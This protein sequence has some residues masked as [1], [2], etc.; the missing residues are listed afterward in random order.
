MLNLL[1]F[2]GNHYVN[3]GALVALIVDDVAPSIPLPLEIVAELGQP[4]ARPML[5]Q[6]ALFE[7]VDDLIHLFPLNLTDRLLIS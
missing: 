1:E 4:C 3:V 6:R 7:E 2:S 5:E